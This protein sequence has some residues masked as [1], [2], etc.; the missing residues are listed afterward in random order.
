MLIPKHELAGLNER[1]ELM[2]ASEILQWAA[3]T[4]PGRTAIASSM[5][6]PTTVLI[7]M[8][9]A[10]GLDMTVIFVDTGV[11]FPETLALRDE[12][13]R[14]FGVRIITV[15]PHKSFEEQYAEYGRH[16]Y[17]H[18]SDTDPPGY[19][20]CCELRKEVP[21]LEAVRGHFDCVLGGLTRDEGGARKNIPMLTLDPRLGAYRRYPLATWT[22]DQIDEYVKAHSIPVH[23]LYAKGYASIGCRTCTT[24]IQ[25]G[26]PKRAGRWRHIREN[27]PAL[28]AEGMYC[29][30]NLEDKKPSGKPPTP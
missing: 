29:G 8:A 21:F 24:P 5:Q 16:L 30:L 10:L 14:R 19:Q 15:T 1:L 2:P 4:F 11:H 22:N 25:P 18:D 20:E 27:N 28:A 3:A 23:P 13:A 12:L 26:E 9:A 6:K 17:L 7:H